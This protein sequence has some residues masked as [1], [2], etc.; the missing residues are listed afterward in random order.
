MKR[1]R[2]LILVILLFGILSLI[3]TY[4]LMLYFSRGMPYVQVP[5][6]GYE[7]VP[8]IQGDHL[9]FY[10]YLWLGKD[11]LLGKNTYLQKSI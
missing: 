6:D 8:I 1:C 7:I 11:A 9:Q 2:E 5:A 3:Y 4:P 10:Y